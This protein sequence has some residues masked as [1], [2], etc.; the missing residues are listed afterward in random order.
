VAGA[1]IAG[2]RKSHRDRCACWAS[3]DI[4]E[5][6]TCPHGCVY[7]YAV[8]SRTAAKRYYRSHDPKS[9]FLGKRGESRAAVD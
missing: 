8:N 4:G 3:R 9:E 2:V 1:A 5:Y 6:D 7:C